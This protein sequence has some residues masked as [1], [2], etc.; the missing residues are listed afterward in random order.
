MY[1]TIRHKTETKS[2]NLDA[3]EGAPGDV[4]TADFQTAGRGRLDHTWQSARAC[5]LMMSCVVDAANEAPEKIMLLPLVTGLAVALALEKW[6]RDVAIKWPNDVL[7]RS[8]KIC[9]ILCQRHNDAIIAGIG[10]NVRQD[11][12]PEE[13]RSRATSLALEGADVAVEAVRNAVLDK[14][15]ALLNEWR[16]GNIELILAQIKKRDALFNKKITFSPFPGEYI[17]GIAQGIAPDGALIIDS[18]PRYAGEVAN[19]TFPAK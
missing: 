12:F 4:F 19:I 13:I 7:V 14:L 8:R 11:T 3:M 9:G 10:I 16:I 6:V 5:N 1:W 15:S 18:I 17:S 2:T